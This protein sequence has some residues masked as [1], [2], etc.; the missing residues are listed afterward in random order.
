MSQFAKTGPAWLNLRMAA[1]RSGDS[2]A[3]L[4]ANSR[5]IYFESAGFPG[6]KVNFQQS[7]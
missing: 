7:S 6:Q 3:G 5:E 4:S 2:R 1:A